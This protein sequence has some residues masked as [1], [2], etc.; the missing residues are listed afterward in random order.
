MI[1]QPMTFRNS[2]KKVLSKKEKSHANPWKAKHG[3]VAID[4]PPPASGKNEIVVRGPEA[5]AVA[6]AVELRAFVAAKAKSTQ[7]ITINVDASNIDSLLE[8]RFSFNFLI[9]KLRLVLFSN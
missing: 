7:T 2:E 4:I 8:T 1:F 6:C 9:I 3:I 5:G